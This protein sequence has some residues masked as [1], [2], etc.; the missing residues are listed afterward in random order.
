MDDAGLADHYGL[1][2]GALAAAPPGPVTVVNLFKLR[3]VAEYPP[4]TTHDAATSGVEAM[5]AYG[6]VSGTASRP[7]GAG[8]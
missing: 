4:G 1:D 5:L 6:A 3:E 8:S 2:P 7:S